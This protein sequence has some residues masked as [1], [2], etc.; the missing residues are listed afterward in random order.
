MLID[1]PEIRKNFS[2][3]TFRS[4]KT[5]KYDAFQQAV[6]ADEFAGDL[7]SPSHTLLLSG[8]PLF[9]LAV[10]F[11]EMLTPIGMLQSAEHSSQRNVVTVTEFGAA[12]PRHFPGRMQHSV[13]LQRIVGSQ[14]NMLG[15]LY[16]WLIEYH[17]SGAYNVAPLLPLNQ[18][19]KPLHATTASEMV[20][21][22]FGLYL[23]EFTET[24]NYIASYYW[25]R[26]V[27]QGHARSFNANNPTVLENV[28]LVF[29]REVAAPNLLQ[30]ADL[31]KQITI[32]DELGDSQN[33]NTDI[34]LPE[35][36]VFAPTSAP[37]LELPTNPQLLPPTPQNE[38]GFE[39]PLA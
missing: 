4:V 38:P 27:L 13:T 14:G 5:D 6:Y 23:V 28:Q 24:G 1:E 22:P 30:L 3:D 29:G 8:P 11:R 25:E 2:Y 19:G 7:V 37:T 16:R 31:T 12:A 36:P 10:T 18:R 20:D 39:R 21:V 26:C 9:R 15:L 33:V 34:V 35:R 17:K 32:P